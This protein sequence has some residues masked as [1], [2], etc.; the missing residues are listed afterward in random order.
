[1]DEQQNQTPEEEEDDLTLVKEE[2]VVPQVYLDANTTLYGTIN[3]L[4]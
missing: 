4:E 1:M 3:A 2:I